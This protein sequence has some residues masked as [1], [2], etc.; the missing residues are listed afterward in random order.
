MECNI[1]CA[2]SRIHWQDRPQRVFT[3]FHVQ[4]TML[5]QSYMVHHIQREVERLSRFY[6]DDKMRALSHWAI[7]QID[8]KLKDDHARE[9]V[10]FDGP[11]DGG[12][13]AIWK[14]SNGE[15]LC[16]A[17]I[18]GSERVLSANVENLDDEEEDGFKPESFDG[19]AVTELSA[20]LD[21]LVSPPKFRKARLERALQAYKEAIK[22]GR[23]IVLLPVVFGQR[24]TS[25]DEALQALKDRLNRDR[26][27]FARH[28]VREIDLVALNELM[29]RA[30]EDPPR[31]LQIV[32]TDW[33]LP[34]YK[35]ESGYF[36]AL[37]PAHSLVEL[38]RDQDLRIYLANYRFTLGPTSVQ[39]GMRLTLESESER[40][41]FHLYHN[42]ISIVGQKISLQ[43]GQLR[44]DRLQVVNGLQTIETLYE[45]AKANGDGALNG[46]NVLVRLID[47]EEQPNHESD[48]SSLQERI[49]EYSNKQNSIEPRDLR[50][51]DRVQ[52][53]LQHEIEALKSYSYQRKRGQYWQYGRR[54]DPSVVDNEKAGQRILSF[55][56]GRPADAKNRRKMLFVTQG[57]DKNG[58][59]EN[60]FV[61]NMSAEAM[62]I[63]YLLYEKLPDG[64]GPLQESVVEHG[65]MILLAMWGTT[66]QTWSRI[67][68]SKTG[69]PN[70]QR[71]LKA[72][73][74]RLDSGCLDREVKQIA[75]EL[76]RR[77]TS[78]AS[79]EL[80]RRIMEARR[81][82]KKEPTLRNVLVNFRYDVWEQKLLPTSVRQRLAKKLGRGM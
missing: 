66:F 22:E 29:D 4:E 68:F 59:Y 16:I 14:H 49:A 80:N 72:F 18:K 7:R 17:Q 10:S 26:Q 67:P 58:L 19:S 12:I 76:I 61:N 73:F 44:I 25:F 65:D 20:A 23:K 24:T 78:V 64:K 27:T 50:S 71:R 30:F 79:K 62:L 56:L 37:A 75:N 36:L 5:G 53:R 69:K 82:G 2:T 34:P 35:V 42:G 41:R 51:N 74:E 77:L 33:P 6:G 60:V 31:T 13:D 63:P 70:N 21:K 39:R 9:V 38:R 57:E 81:A 43:P 48:Q 8:P 47:V 55:W 28:S 3:S 45:F 32:T 52:K 54:R 46:V 1:K 11:G 15:E 40:T